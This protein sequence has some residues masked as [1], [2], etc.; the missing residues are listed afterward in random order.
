MNILGLNHTSYTGPQA[1]RDHGKV[2]TVSSPA[3][4]GATNPHIEVDVVGSRLVEK[5]G[6]VM[7]QIQDKTQNTAKEL[8]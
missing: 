2:L 6:S 8:P 7:S 5:R 1:H 4:D 3:G